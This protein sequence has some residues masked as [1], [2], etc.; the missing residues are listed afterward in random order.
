MRKS[1]LIAASNLRRTKG[2][3]VA[4]V[5]LILLASAML[6]LGLMLSTDYKRNFD[7]CHDRL[8]DG[9]VTLVMTGNDT[10]QQ[11]FL[12]RTLEEEEGV[13]EY[14]CQDALFMVGS[15][16]Y[17]GGEVNTEFVILEKESALSRPVGRMEIV[18][19]GEGKSGVYLPMLYGADG[20]IEL[21]DMMDI[22]IGSHVMRY[23][24]CG[25][26]NS[27]MAG[28][29]NCSMSALLLTADRYE[30]LE[31]LGY[32]PAST[33]ASVRIR[34]KEESQDFEAALKNKISAAYPAQRV[35]SNAYGMVSSSRYISQ[36][37]C[38]SVVNAMAFFVTL[39]ALVVISSKVINYIQENM[40]IL[41]AL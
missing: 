33:F 3:T 14:F 22:N 19:E 15:F 40:K 34:D 13:E 39:I 41:G 5:A 1:L 20:K 9:H 24:V 2:Q 17:N 18:E 23:Q 21:G 28:S 8:N 37:I 38:S 27:A 12:Y 6:N 4:I 11:E 35:L 10:K 26:L 7:R 29:H 32:A 16:A 36:M 25:F 30:E 31:R